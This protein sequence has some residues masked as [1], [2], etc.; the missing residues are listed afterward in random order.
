M[1]DRPE[2]AGPSVCHLSSVIC[3]FEASLSELRQPPFLG[4]KHLV[5]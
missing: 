2:Y 1:T 4:G 5:Y 3:H